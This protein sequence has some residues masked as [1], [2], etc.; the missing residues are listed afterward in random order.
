MTSGWQQRSREFYSTHEAA[1]DISSATDPSRNS[2]HSFGHLVGNRPIETFTARTFGRQRTHREL[3]STHSLRYGQRSSSALGHLVGNRPIEKFTAQLRTSRRQQ[4]HREI[5]SKDILSVTD[6]S[7]NLQHPFP[8]LRAAIEQRLHNPTRRT[9]RQTY[10][11][12]YVPTYTHTYTRTYI[13][14]YIHTPTYIHTDIQ[15]D[16]H[17]DIQVDKCPE[18]ATCCFPNS[19]T[20]SGP[21]AVTSRSR[22]SKRRDSLLG[23]LLQVMKIVDR[24]I[25]L[26]N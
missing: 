7:R 5:Y 3:Y 18:L 25:E 15:T 6:P 12:T 4:T 20:G 10:R 21:Y 9:Y 13:H 16:I 11:H 22:V 1:S 17:T 26:A 19:G 14:T 2:Q 8:A 23:L 24:C